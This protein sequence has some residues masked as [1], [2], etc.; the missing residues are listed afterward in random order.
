M[1]LPKE[2][3]T[4]MRKCE[5]GVGEVQEVQEVVGAE[6][7]MAP[8]PWRFHDNE[9]RITLDDDRV[10]SHEENHHDNQLSK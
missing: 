3:I 1:D 2:L 6:F 10:R 9:R 7:S 8:A 5:G 4:R